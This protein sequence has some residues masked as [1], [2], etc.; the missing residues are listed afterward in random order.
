M[1]DNEMNRILL[2]VIIS[3]CCSYSVVAEEPS[4]QELGAASLKKLEQIGKDASELA[5]GAVKDIQSI[6]KDTKEEVQNKWSTFIENRTQK[7][8]M[9]DDRSI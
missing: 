9:K 3:I 6:S 8:A 7:K 4:W 5:S 1:E 2:A